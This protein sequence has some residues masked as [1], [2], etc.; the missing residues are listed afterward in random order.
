MACFKSPAGSEARNNAINQAV[1]SEELMQNV[2]NK[3]HKG[4][5]IRSEIISRLQLDFDFTPDA[6]VRFATVIQET[7]EFLDL[8]EYN[9]TNV[10]KEESEKKGDDMNTPAL[11]NSNKTTTP[12]AY[13]DYTL[14]YDSGRQKIIL[15]APVDMPEAQFK[16]MI[17][18]LNVLKDGMVR[19]DGEQKESTE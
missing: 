5:P 1:M 18:W 2:I 16:R 4:L 10:Q 9:G 13:N 17:D 6:A 8:S 3:W 15:R 19:K 7:F 11:E 12:T 14:T